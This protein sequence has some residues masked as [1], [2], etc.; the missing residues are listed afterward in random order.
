MLIIFGG[1]P[2]VGKTTIAKKLAHKIGATYIRIDSIEQ[3]IK[4]SLLQVDDFVD[5]GYVV[6]YGLAKDNL[7]LGNKVI[8]DSVN[9]IEI[10]RKAWLAVAQ[11]VGCKAVEIEVVCSDKAEH[12]RRVE[13]RIPDI[14]GHK[15]PNWQ[16]VVDRDY[17]P[18][19]TNHL[20]IDTANKQVDEA[21][22][23]LLSKLSLK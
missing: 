1:L 21:F 18:R 12:Q 9:P 4:K 16:Q 3:A 15:L 17:E 11:E 13:E 20:I 8:A 2:G 7:L 10:T 23:E 5:S 14:I 22:E 19:T 6:G